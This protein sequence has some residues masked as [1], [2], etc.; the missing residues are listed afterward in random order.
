[1]LNVR[2]KKLINHNEL[3]NLV[4]NGILEKIDFYSADSCPYGLTYG[5]WTVEWWRWFLKTPKSTNPILDDSGKFASVNQPNRNVWFLGGKVGDESLSFPKRFCKIPSSYSIL[6][7]V[8]NCEANPLECPELTTSKQLREKVESDENTIISK[9]CKVDGNFVPVQ[10]IK[11]DPNIFHLKI[12][13]DNAY[14]VAEGGETF[15]AADGYW[16]FL[17]PLPVGEHEVS[18]R[19]SCEYGKLNSGADYQLQIG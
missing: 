9:Y 1:M 15:A 17:R 13:R 11:S 5:R 18:F 16:V 6:F 19:G 3:V 10:R 2:P 14:D 4:S 8:I 7:P 12:D